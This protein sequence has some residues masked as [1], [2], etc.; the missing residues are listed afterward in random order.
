MVEVLRAIMAGKTTFS[1]I[2]ADSQ[3]REAQVN[4]TLKN[5]TLKGLIAGQKIAHNRNRYSVTLAGLAYLEAR[6]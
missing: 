4:S 2:S 1:E 5:L 3:M 6:T